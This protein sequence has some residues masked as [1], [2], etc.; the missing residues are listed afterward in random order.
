MA[1]N[2][3]FCRVLLISSLA[4]D[5]LNQVTLELSTPPYVEPDGILFC[6]MSQLPFLLESNTTYVASLEKGGTQFEISEVNVTGISGPSNAAKA[7]NDWNLT[8]VEICA[9]PDLLS[10]DPYYSHSYS[11]RRRALPLADVF[12]A[13]HED[14]AERGPSSLQV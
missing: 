9:L 7:V 10:T 5:T 3:E 13:C 8:A 2:E 12:F 1:L 6:F 4:L 11:F 14:G